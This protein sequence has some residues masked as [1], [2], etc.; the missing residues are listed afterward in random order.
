MTVL[1]SGGQH[2][3][4]RHLRQ[5]GGGVEHMLKTA[6]QGQWTEGKKA[7]FDAEI[8]S[9]ATAV[10]EH[11]ICQTEI[12][13]LGREVFPHLARL[14][15][16]YGNTGI[17]TR[18]ACEPPDWYYEDHGWE[19]R[20]AIFQRHALDLLEEVTLKAAKRASIGLDDIGALVVNTI[21]GLAIPSLDAKLMNRLQLP[22][23][24]ERLPIFG[25]G[26]GGGVGGLARAARYAQAMPA[27]SHVLFLTIDLC[28]LCLRIADPS[29]AMFVAAA[30]FG[31]GAAGVVL[32]NTLGSDGAAGRGKVLAVGD[33]FWPNTEQIM[34]WDIKEDGFG[35]V[36][37]PELPGLIR[38]EFMPALK[39]FLDASGM[40]LGEFSYHAPWRGQDPKDYS[41]IIGAV[42]RGPSLFLGRAPRFRQHVVAHGSVRARQR[43]KRRRSGAAS[44]YGVRPR[45]LSLFCCR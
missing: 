15:S 12:T 20:T 23:S 31:D 18:Y 22:H 33:H 24:V 32:R 16:L 6:S 42:A 1:R 43:G 21:T 8:A 14:E 34:G 36:L 17:E 39:G 44:A 9:V 30:L 13:K 45:L 27:G 26:C 40:D 38:T 3:F 35:V 25:L 19:T 37:S 7:K 41:G 2:E 4:K 29:T 28:S 5:A 11:K 10:P